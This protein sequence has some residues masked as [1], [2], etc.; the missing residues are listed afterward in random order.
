VK[1]KNVT[2]V[3][4]AAQ[5]VSKEASSERHALNCV[6]EDHVCSDWIQ[7]P[8]NREVFCVDRIREGLRTDREGATRIRK[9]LPEDLKGLAEEWKRLQRI[10]SCAESLPRAERGEVSPVGLDW[11]C[12]NRISC[13]VREAASSP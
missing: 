7:C 12:V 3:T 4:R 10:R 11:K 6:R 8:E 9:G 1:L 13:P 5:S 2:A